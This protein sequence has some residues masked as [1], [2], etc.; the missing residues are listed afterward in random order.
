MYDPNAM[1]AE[2]SGQVQS[3][4]A[5]DAASDLIVAIISYGII[6]LMVIGWSAFAFYIARSI[7]LEMVA[8]EQGLKPAVTGRG[9]GVAWALHESIGLW[10]TT[11]LFFAAMISPIPGIYFE[12]WRK[13]RFAEA[14]ETVAPSQDESW[15][16]S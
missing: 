7:H 2:P 9:S 15:T 1:L 3:P 8:V 12:M 16:Q 11:A 10:P 14:D 6:G 5:D 4:P 13:R